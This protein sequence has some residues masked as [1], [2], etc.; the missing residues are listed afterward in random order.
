MANNRKINVITLG[1][2]KNIVDSEKLSAQIHAGGFDVTHNTVDSDAGIVIINTCGFINDAREESIDTILQ[3]AEAQKAGKIERFY[4]IGCLSE[5]YSEALRKEIPEVRR[6]FGVNSMSDILA[7]LG[8]KQ[9]GTHPA[10]RI[11]TGPSHYAY[12]KIA[13]GC[14]RT[15]SF[16]AIPGIRG[17]YVSQTIEN[18]IAEAYKLAENGVRELILIA[19]DLSYYGLDIYRQRSLPVLI[20]ELAKIDRIEWIRLNYLY[21]ADFPEELIKVI[22]DNPKVC[23]Y[24]DIPIQHISDKMLSIMQR[25]HNRYETE[26]ILNRLRNDIPDVVIRTTL[27]AGHPGETENEFNELKEFIKSF[28]FDRLGVFKYSHEEGTRSGKSYNDE[29]PEETKELRVA[30]LMEIQQ[31]ISEILN[32]RYIGKVLKTIIDRKEGDY[33]VGRTEY[34]TPEV[35]QEILINAKHNLKPGDFYQ[36]KISQS[37]EFDLFGTP[38]I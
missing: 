11:L 5:K 17:K 16:C 37:T 34:D 3:Y 1:C 23:K 9:N 26:K 19:Q 8:I 33:F 31:D 10:G 13:E 22:C 20:T 35:D 6:Y 7:E 18:L 15:C 30:E 29:I 14:D 21:P 38:N 25:S 36:I 28:R 12:L 4:V 32:R 24:I 27:I 2:S